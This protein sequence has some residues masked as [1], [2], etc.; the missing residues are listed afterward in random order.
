MVLVF[1]RKA[2][3]L[4]LLSVAKC[5]A[6]LALSNHITPKDD[7][8]TTL[9]TPWTTP[10]VTIARNS[11]TH[12]HIGLCIPMVPNFEGEIFNILKLP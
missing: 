12:A 1:G 3:I 7:R 11:S 8:V 9:Y 5:L 6:P 10:S 2:P 4:Q